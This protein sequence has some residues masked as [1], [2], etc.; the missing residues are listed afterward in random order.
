MARKV[1]QCEAL[2]TLTVGQSHG[3]RLNGGDS[4]VEAVFPL[5]RRSGTFIV[6]LASIILS[7]C[8]TTNGLSS[9]NDYFLSRKWFSFALAFSGQ[10]AS[11]LTYRFTLALVRSES[12]K[13]TTSYPEMHWRAMKK[14]HSLS[15]SVFSCWRTKSESTLCARQKI[16]ANKSERK[17]ILW[18][19]RASQWAD[20]VN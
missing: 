20:A 16:E 7:F 5:S 12:I 14:C 11:A 1:N 6:T 8:L 3:L 9:D 19:F 10:D 13:C 17:L 18:W 4:Q 2:V 15:P